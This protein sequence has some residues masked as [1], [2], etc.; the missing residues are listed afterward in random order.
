[1]KNYFD[2]QREG[3]LA[4][5]DHLYDEK[6]TTFRGFRQ[7]SGAGDIRTNQHTKAKASQGNK[8]YYASG[9]MDGTGAD[10]TKGLVN[11]ESSQTGDAERFSQ[12]INRTNGKRNSGTKSFENYLRKK[13][14][15]MAAKEAERVAK[16]VI[17]GKKV[18]NGIKVEIS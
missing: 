7:G 3:T 6:D 16:K 15:R 10:P 18:T 14:I 13:E 2:K 17:N 12:D 9:A 1:M 4:Q 8:K 5:I 11:W